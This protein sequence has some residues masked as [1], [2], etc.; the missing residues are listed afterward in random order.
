[1]IFYYA[2]VPLILIGDILLFTS[3]P[4]LA[5]LYLRRLHYHNER[6]AFDEKQR[7]HDYRFKIILTMDDASISRHLA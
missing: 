7:Q 5:L 4:L 3:S 1:M 2:G 6:A